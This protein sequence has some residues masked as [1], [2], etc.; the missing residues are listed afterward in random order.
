MEGKGERQ[1]VYS[2]HLRADAACNLI[3]FRTSTSSSCFDSSM[4]ACIEENR[5]RINQSQCLTRVLDPQII[6][7][8]LRSAHLPPE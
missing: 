2:S 1:V 7:L 6:E 8:R 3:H 5:N 4:L